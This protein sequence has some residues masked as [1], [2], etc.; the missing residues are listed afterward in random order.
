MI[1]PFNENKLDSSKLKDFKRCPRLFFYSHVLGWRSQTPN[2]HL[3]FG[4]AWHEAMEHL[5]LNGYGNDSII[6]AFD[7]F[8]IRYREAFPPE[9]DGMFKRKTPDNAFLVLS[10]YA[11]Y[12]PYQRD[13]DNYKTLYTEIA[14]SVAVDEKRTLFFRQDSI[15]EHKKTGHIISREHKTG[16]RTWMWEEQFLLDAQVGTY[17]H[18]L[19]CLF[20]KELVSGVEVNGSFFLDRKSEPKSE[21]IFRRFLIRRNEDQ[22]QVW[23]DTTRYYMWQIEMEYELLNDAKEDDYTLRC[24]PLRDT[25]CMDYS[26]MCEYHDFCMAWPNPLRKCFEPPLGFVQRYWDPTEGP[27]KQTFKF[28][29]KEY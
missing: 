18:V 6:A 1:L 15:L 24:F 3:E 29:T 21:D 22:M 9:T 23:I 11:T 27:A 10:K 14:G 5:L 2:I 8:L 17:N 20:P 26:R 19:Y 16:S 4:S 25:S 28:E 12:P 7:K 13:F